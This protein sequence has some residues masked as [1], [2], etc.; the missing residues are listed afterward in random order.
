MH[1][2]YIFSNI[3]GIFIFNEH[4]RL[5][6]SKVFKNYEDD[7]K[8]KLDPFYKNYRNLREPTGKEIS[9]ILEFFKKNEYFKEFFEKNVLITKKAIKSSVKKDHLV[10]Q[11]INNLADAEK[12]TNTLVKRL[13]D[14]YELFNPE[15][16]KSVRDHEKFVDLIISKSKKALLAEINVDESMGTDLPK[17]DVKP[18]IDLAKTVKS[19]FELRRKQEDYL[20]K[21]ME[22]LCPNMLAITGATIGAKLIAQAGSM[23]KLTRFPSSTIQLLGAERA[24]FRH[25]KTKSRSP[26][27]GYL[28]EHPLITNN[29]KSLHG[30]IARALADKISIAAKVDYFKGK[31]CGDKLRQELDKR[32]AK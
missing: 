24:L 9:R 7:K 29:K 31:F 15:I 19:I 17:S 26:K 13:R 14:W 32:F 8:V 18:I 11:T 21:M 2:K 27:Y 5:L 22:A 6:E 25:L 12:V 4:Y 1:K 10:V 3:I 16:S 28:H 30:K 20:K 23:K